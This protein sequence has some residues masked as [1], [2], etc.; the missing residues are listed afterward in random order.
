[1][2]IIFGIIMGL[3]CLV[4]TTILALVLGIIDIVRAFK[5]NRR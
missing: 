5:N 3:I 2:I 1:M 4:Q